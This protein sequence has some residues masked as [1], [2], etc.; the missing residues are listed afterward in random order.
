[1]KCE[2]PKSDSILYYCQGT[3]AP[4]RAPRNVT[5]SPRKR[6]GSGLLFSSGGGGRSRNDSSSSSSSSS[7]RYRRRSRS[8]SRSSSSSSHCRSHCYC[9]S[10]CHC[11]SC[12]GSGSRRCRSAKTPHAASNH[13]AR[14]R[15]PSNAARRPAQP[16]A[17]GSPARGGRRGVVVVAAA[18]GSRRASSQTAG[19]FKAATAGHVPREI[20][21]RGGER[22]RARV[23]RRE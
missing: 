8:S 21:R 15:Q 18:G 17:A 23:R 5:H 16:R 6:D 13:R 7:S 14:L 20:R 22:E 10:H 1:M 12:S 11:R 19:C 4:W 9:R 2:V 3:C